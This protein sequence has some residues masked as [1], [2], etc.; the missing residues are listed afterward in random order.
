MVERARPR[1]VPRTRPSV[2]PRR[3]WSPLRGWSPSGAAVRFVAPALPHG[4]LHVGRR[5]PLARVNSAPRGSR[6]QLSAGSELGSGGVNGASGT[7]T[8]ALGMT[9]SRMRTRVLLL[10]RR[11]LW[12]TASVSAANQCM[13][14]SPT[15]TTPRAPRR[16]SS[17]IASVR[18]VARDCAKRTRAVQRCA[19]SSR[20]LASDDAVEGTQPRPTS[21]PS[22]GRPG[23]GHAPRLLA[24]AAQAIVGGVEST[25]ANASYLQR[26]GGRMRARATG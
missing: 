15:L 17:A 14:R 22:D 11:M 13:S 6:G 1:L 7:A 2:A 25:S 16:A 8:R 4:R 5:S 20:H 19:P 10:C 23:E 26:E 3:R 18:D 24:P 9:R 21:T 12:K